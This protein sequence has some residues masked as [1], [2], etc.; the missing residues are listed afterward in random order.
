LK[1]VAMPGSGIRTWVNDPEP[2]LFSSVPDGA[3]FVPADRPKDRSRIKVGKWGY[4]L[5]GYSFY[6]FPSPDGVRRDFPVFVRT[7]VDYP[8]ES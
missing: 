6:V 3:H 4:N 1:E 5:D 2:V 8:V 7:L